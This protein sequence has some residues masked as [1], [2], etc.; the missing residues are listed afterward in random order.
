MKE[1]R[2]NNKHYYTLELSHDGEVTVKNRDG[3]P[4]DPDPNV[5]IPP[6]TSILNTR[7]ITIIEAEGSGWIYIDPP[8][9][10]RQV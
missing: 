2:L 7:T 4:I 9:V 1:S 3:K 8:G 10:W 5:K 6:I